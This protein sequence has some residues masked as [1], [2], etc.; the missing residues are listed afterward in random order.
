M[1]KLIN[2]HKQDDRTAHIYERSEGGYLVVLMRPGHHEEFRDLRDKSE[3]YA[4][5]LAE[6]FVT[7]IGEFA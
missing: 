3:H 6:N 2:E 1:T 4:Q 7:K 5:D